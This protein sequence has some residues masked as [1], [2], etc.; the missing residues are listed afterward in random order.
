V[1]TFDAGIL[2]DVRGRHEVAIRTGRHPDSNVVVWA[3]VLDDAVFVRSARGAKGRWYRDLVGGD[4]ATLEAG[5]S[6][7]AVRGTP[8]DDPGTVERVSGEYRRKYGSSPYLQ[9]VLRPEV[10]ATTLRLDPR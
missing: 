5:P 7:L 10:V 4:M 6:R 8:V 2:R 3:V 1:T 9:S